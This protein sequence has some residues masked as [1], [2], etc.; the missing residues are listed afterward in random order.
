MDIHNPSRSLSVDDEDVGEPARASWLQALPAEKHLQLKCVKVKPAQWLSV[1][2]AG[3][4]WEPVLASRALILS[5]LCL[6]KGWIVTEEDLFAPTRC[7]LPKDSGVQPAS[8]AAA[9]RSALQKLKYLKD[10]SQNTLAAATRLICDI[11]VINGFRILLLASKAQYT[12]FNA[13]FDDLTSPEKTLKF[14]IEWANCTW[15]RSLELT[16][17]SLEDPGLCRCGLRMTFRSAEVRNLT[18]DSPAVKFQDAHAKTHSSY[19]E[20][21]LETRCGSL[22]QWNFYYP[23]KLAMLASENPEEQTRCLQEFQEDLRALW[24][25]QTFKGSILIGGIVARCRL[26]QPYHLWAIALAA[27]SQFAL[28][29]H[30]KLLELVQLSFRSWGQTRI[31]EKANK[32]LR[33]AERRDNASK[34]LPSM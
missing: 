14:S 27:P 8:K 4:I 24:K 25:A 6:R 26:Q 31:N 34:V 33:D 17:D 21:I 12:A 3:Y 32:V 19:V 16:L 30:P 28:P 2:K 29:M 20:L 18:V 9:L 10:R 23:Y 11:D 1:L 13:L 22:V 15:I 7:G 5:S